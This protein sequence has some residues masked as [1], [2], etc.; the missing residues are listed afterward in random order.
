MVSTTPAVPKHVRVFATLQREIA[1]GQWQ[2]GQRIPSEAELVERF[3]VSR[4][5]IGRAMRDLQVAGL[6]ERRRGSGTFVRDTSDR[7]TRAFG[8]LVPS[9]HE[10]QIFAPIG[11]AIVNSPRAREY[12]RIVEGTVPPSEAIVL[13]LAGA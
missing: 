11:R 4:I 13:S 3:E 5:T 1:D 9:S 6:V 2:P 12:R 10:S 8:L 7:A